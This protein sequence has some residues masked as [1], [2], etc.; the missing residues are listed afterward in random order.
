[1]D[2]ANAGDEVAM[3]MLHLV[4]ENVRSGKMADGTRT[5]FRAYVTHE[6]AMRYAASQADAGDRPQLRAAVPEGAREW[7]WRR[8]RSGQVGDRPDLFGALR[9]CEDGRESCVTA[10]ALGPKLTDQRLDAV[11]ASFQGDPAGGKLAEMGLSDPKEESL[12]SLLVRVGDEAS[13]V[14]GACYFV[15][16]VL[17]LARIRQCVV[18]GNFRAAGR[19]L[20]VELG[21]CSPS[22]ASR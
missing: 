6:L 8:A 2:S 15:G 14:V 18:S 5:P 4:G 16:V 3:S 1:M 7:L 19:D 10:F 21:E 17:M 20:C 12:P 22:E 9:G 13:E 11:L